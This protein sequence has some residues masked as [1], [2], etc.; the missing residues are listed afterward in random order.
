MTLKGII[1]AGGSGTRLYPVTKHINKHLLPVYDKPMIYY[2]LS[3]LMMAGIKE[4]LLISTPRDT[5][6]YKALLGNGHHLGIQI[7]YAEQ[8]HPN[9]LAEALIIGEDFIGQDNVCLI[10]GDNVFYGQDLI[11]KLENAKNKLPG[12]VVFAYYVDQPERYG[13]VAFENQRV[14]DIIEKPL[15]PPSHYAVTGL[16][17]YDHRAVAYAKSLTPSKRGELEITDLN[18]LFLQQNELHVEFLG[19]GY[20]W[21]DTGTCQSLMEASQFV[22]LLEQRQGLKIACPE[23]IAWRKGYISS[24]QLEAL[25]E[26]LQKS[27]YGQYLLKLIEHRDMEEMYLGT[28]ELTT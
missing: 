18:R 8:A 27:G 10:L 13:V 4:I 19:R 21:L 28:V 25:A 9:G 15:N 16:Y 3:T 26:P 20:A 24:S 14:I 17:F 5:E 6:T 11:K 7:T 1:L 2:P 12:A 23:E 22:A